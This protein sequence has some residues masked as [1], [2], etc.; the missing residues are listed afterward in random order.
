LKRIHG[1]DERIAV[2][3]YVRMVHFYA[4]LMRNSGGKLGRS[5]AAKSETQ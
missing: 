1:I 3:D 4:T 5:P 2:S